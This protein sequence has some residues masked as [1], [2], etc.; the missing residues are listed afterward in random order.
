[1]KKVDEQEVIRNTK[2]ADVS[3]VPPGKIN[4]RKD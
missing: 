4:V 3:S 2:S 1:M